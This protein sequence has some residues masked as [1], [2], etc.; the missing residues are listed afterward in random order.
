MKPADPA[1]AALARLG[2]QET[3]CCGSEPPRN[4]AWGDCWC[5]LPPEHPEQECV[6]EPCRDRYGAPGWRADISVGDCAE[7]G[8][9]LLWGGVA[10]VPHTRGWHAARRRLLLRAVHRRLSEELAFGHDALRLAFARDCVLILW[11]AVLPGTVAYYRTEMPGEI[12]DADVDREQL[13][14]VLGRGVRDGIE[15]VHYIRPHPMMVKYRV[16]D[17]RGR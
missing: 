14:A 11:R 16:F 6:C 4:G 17:G 2:L 9:K 8:G 3:Y 7:C 1:A 5:T 10:W 15:R 13:L 12:W